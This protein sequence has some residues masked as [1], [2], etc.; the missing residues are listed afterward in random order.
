MARVM[1]SFFVLVLSAYCA[2]GCTPKDCAGVKGG[3]ATLDACGRCVGADTGLEPCRCG[4]G[5]VNPAI[6]EGCDDGNTKSEACRYGVKECVIC[7]AQCQEEAGE[8]S[9]CGD[10]TKDERELCDNG[11]AN[12]DTEVDACRSNCFP[13]RCTDG[14]KDSG[15]EC[16][17]GNDIGNDGCSGCTVDPAGFV[18]V[19]DGAFMMGSPENVIR[20]DWR[21]RK[22]EDH[23]EVVI[24]KGFFLMKHEV[25]QGE[26]QALMGN[27]P[28]KFSSCGPDCPVET[29]SWFDAIAYANALSEK[30][31]LKPCYSGSGDTINWDKS[32]N[33]Y[34]LPT[35]A[36]WEY[37]ARAGQS[38][39]YAGSDDVDSI[40]WFDDN[41]GSSRPVGKKK[42]NAWGLYDMSGNVSEWVWDWKGDYQQGEG[43]RQYAVDPDGP[44]SNGFMSFT[45]RVT[46][47]GSSGSRYASDLRVAN[48]NSAPPARGFED[49]GFRLAR[50]A[51]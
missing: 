12:S 10:G 38:T 28:S 33:G 47:G 25:T 39:E 26:Y 13:A 49:I 20:R 18:F 15:E 32:C 35:E 21:G 24:T 9:F 50:T 46:R 22:D 30:Q 36:E 2:T 14:V 11:G 43:D 19:D 42:P 51:K 16:D 29:V 7:N 37:A 44:F 5:E 27:N 34:R 17:D 3:S 8:V 1:V 41:S 48:R 40:G 6:G 31:N 4:D 45:S 23:H